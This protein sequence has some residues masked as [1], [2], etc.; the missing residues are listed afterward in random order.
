MMFNKKIEGLNKIDLNELGCWDL[1]INPMSDMGHIV[2]QNVDKKIKEETIIPELV[3]RNPHLTAL[4]QYPYPNKI[5]VTRLKRKIPTAHELKFEESYAV[6][7]SIPKNIINDVL[8]YGYVYLE[9]TKHPIR[10]FESK[11]VCNHCK[12]Q[13]HL[14]IAC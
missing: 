4:T 10:I 1:V 3:K 7:V 9:Y 5:K 14:D 13:G 8:K 12:K 11:I 2:I 6:K